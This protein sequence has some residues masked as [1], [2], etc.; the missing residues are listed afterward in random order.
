[1]VARPTFPGCQPD[2]ARRISDFFVRRQLQD[3]AEVGFEG[4]D[5]QGGRLPEQALKRGPGENF[6]PERRHGG[7]LPDPRG[8][9]F[10]GLEP[11]E[12]PLDDGRQEFQEVDIFDEVIACPPFHHLNGDPLVALSGDDDKGNGEAAFLQPVDQLFALRVGQFQVEQHQIDLP[13]LEVF[14][15]FLRGGGGADPVAGPA[16]G[17][18]DE[19]V[20]PR[21][22]VDDQDVG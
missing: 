12:H 10:F 5:Q 15:G 22:V 9:S 11:A 16:N 8:E 7:L 4:L 14:D 6:F 3:L 18:L 2:P 13:L 1:M 19:T 20:Q 17:L 21:I